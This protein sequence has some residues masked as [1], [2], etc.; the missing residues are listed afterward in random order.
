MPINNL[1]EVTIHTNSM[2]LYLNEFIDKKIMC[3]IQKMKNE[4]TV[5]TRYILRNETVSKFKSLTRNKDSLRNL[6]SILLQRDLNC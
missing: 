3:W 4:N 5:N 6:I 1:K 2:K